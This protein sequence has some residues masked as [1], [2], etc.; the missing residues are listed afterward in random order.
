MKRLFNA[1]IF[2]WRGIVSAWRD[3]PSFR[4]EI[5]L[6]VIGIIIACLVEI[7][8]AERALLIMSVLLILVVELL[9]TSIE[10]IV[11]WI[12]EGHRHHLAAKAKD[13]GSAAVL[14]SIIITIVVWIII[15]WPL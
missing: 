15:L 14:I 9:N 5:I 13:C 12:A 8:V 6:A 10:T 2:S 11:D 7:T 3:E 4:C 1:A